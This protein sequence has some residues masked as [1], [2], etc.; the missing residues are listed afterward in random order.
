MNKLL[1]IIVPLFNEEEVLE[2]T[3]NRL[4]NLEQSL[5]KIDIEL[6]FIDDGSTDNSLKILEDNAIKDRRIKIVSLSRNFGHQSAITAGFE[7]AEGDFI[8]VIDADLQDPPE[9]IPKM[10]DKLN[11][12][13]DLVYGKRKLRLGESK[14][15]KNT[16]IFFYQF[17]NYLSYVDMPADTGDFRIFNKKV[18]TSFNTLGEKEKFIRGMFAWLGFKTHAHEYVREKRLKGITKYPL[19]KM[20]N[21][22]LNGILSFSNKPLRIVTRLGFV[23][24]LITILLGSITA[25]LRIF[26]LVEIPYLTSILLIVAFFGSVQILILGIIGEYIAKIFEEVKNRPVYITNKEVNFD[27]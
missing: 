27:K 10:L 17:F 22:A 21:F 20:I 6:I 18:L 11:E 26:M 1:T 15:K 13:Y 23:I 7:K 24:L 16:A 12:G 3:I 9:E 19:S 2:S 8:C 25:Y 14:F 4:L 5:F